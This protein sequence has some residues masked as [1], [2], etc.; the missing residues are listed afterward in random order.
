MRALPFAGGYALGLAIMAPAKTPRAVVERLHGVI[1]RA[2][3]SAELKERVVAGGSALM[4]SA[5]PAVYSAFLK[6]E[7]ERWRTVATAANIR[8]H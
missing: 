3:L 8:V 7:F 2:A 1:T 5:S 4:E 6:Q